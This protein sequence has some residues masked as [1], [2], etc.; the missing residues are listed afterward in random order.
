MAPHT[1]D[2]G[3]STD[4]MKAQH[5]ELKTKC[6]EKCTARER[7]SQFLALKHSNIHRYKSREV[8]KDQ[9]EHW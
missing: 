5:P 2:L 7:Q 3:Y 8:M 9:V 6:L 4:R 1:E